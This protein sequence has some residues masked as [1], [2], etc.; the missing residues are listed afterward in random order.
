M[1][2]SR[3]FVKG[4]IAVTFLSVLI[5]RPAILTFFVDIA[6]ALIAVVS[7]CIFAVCVTLMGLNY[8]D[9]H[10]SKATNMHLNSRN[11]NSSEGISS[12]CLS[13][14][15]NSSCSLFSSIAEKI[16]SSPIVKMQLQNESSVLRGSATV[17]QSQGIY[18]TIRPYGLTP[19]ELLACA[20][21]P[22]AYSTESTTCV[23]TS[24]DEIMHRIFE[25]T[26]R[27]YVETW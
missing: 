20:Y 2:D 11:T 10:Y 14:V 15:K 26:Y 18:E 7:G 23:S 1:V 13:W 21:G 4:T 3:L 9:R 5:A 22:T 25:Y 24:I 6:L 27:D 19:H 12:K 16:S 17:P 8:I